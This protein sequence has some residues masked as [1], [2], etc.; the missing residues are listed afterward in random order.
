MPVSAEVAPSATLLDSSVIAAEAEP[1]LSF[2]ESASHRERPHFYASAGYLSN[3]RTPHRLVG[4]SR[5]EPSIKKRTQRV[6]GRF[7]TRLFIL[8]RQLLPVQRA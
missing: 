3:E 6:Q 2:V 4:G 8:Q 5:C 1:V 7:F